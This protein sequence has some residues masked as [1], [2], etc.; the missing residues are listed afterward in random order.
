MC[1]VY[2][3]LKKAIG[4]DQCPENF[5]YPITIV[6]PD[7]KIILCEQGDED[8]GLD[9]FLE[10]P[11]STFFVPE[12]TAGPDLVFIVQFKGPDEDYIDVPVFVQAKL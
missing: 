12:D 6:R 2:S 11:N 4:I 3:T 10:S 5:S 7:Y 1:Y 8:F 9:Q